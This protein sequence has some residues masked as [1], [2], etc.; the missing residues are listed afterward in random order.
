MGR[1]TSKWATK[2][3]W[4]G[5]MARHSQKRWISFR[6]HEHN[7]DHW[8]WRSPSIL[9]RW[10]KSLENLVQAAYLVGGFRYFLFFTPIP[11]EMM[12]FDE[13]LFQMGG[14]KHQLV[15]VVSSYPYVS[16]SNQYNLTTNSPGASSFVHFDLRPTSHRSF[17]YNTVCISKEGATWKLAFSVWRATGF[18]FC[19][20][21]RRFCMKY[22]SL[23]ISMLC[24][25]PQKTNKS[26]LI[27][28]AWKT[29]FLV[30]WHLFWG[31]VSLGGCTSRKLRSKWRR[32]FKY[33]L[34]ILSSSEAMLVSRG[35]PFL[36]ESW[37]VAEHFQLPWLWGGRLTTT[38]QLN[39]W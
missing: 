10:Y 35:A 16:L 22:I 7:Q 4:K 8:E 27:N 36:S 15:T 2:T 3:I 19:C 31:H 11:V 29:T 38:N 32:L 20:K 23:W 17:I 37:F 14:E 28:S 25:F 9:S 1:Y 6:G 24:Y 26:R 30:T 5:S 21:F 18:C 13:H 39:H 33:Y 12:E 34:F